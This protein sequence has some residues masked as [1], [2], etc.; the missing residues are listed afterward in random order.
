M[1]AMPSPN[2]I[3]VLRITAESG[4]EIRKAA[5]SCKMGISSDYADSLLRCL[6]RD[7]CLEKR[8]N[9]GTYQITP[10]GGEALLSV[11]YQYNE[12]LTARI[13]WSNWLRDR[14]TER[15]AELTD[16]LTEAEKK[17]GNERR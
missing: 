16:I 13:R 17:A 6:Y 7:G 8:L 9:S 10:K 2:E 5:L 1:R 3:K 11:L 4:G 12:T 15:M 14:A